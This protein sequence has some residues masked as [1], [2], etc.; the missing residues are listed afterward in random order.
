MDALMYHS[1]TGHF[2]AD[3]LLPVMTSPMLMKV[4]AIVK[5]HMN[6]EIARKKRRGTH[7]KT[8]VLKKNIN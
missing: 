6:A 2:M 1:T 7:V 4:H 3:V 5:Q 8:T